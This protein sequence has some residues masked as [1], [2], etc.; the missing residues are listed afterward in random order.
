MI[1]FGALLLIILIVMV[2]NFLM[3]GVIYKASHYSDLR[4]KMITDLINGIKTIK[5][6]CWETIFYQ[7]VKHYRDLQYQ[8]MKNTAYLMSLAVPF[9]F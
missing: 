7:K 3:F 2:L 6:Y 9:L 8:N 1:A 5:A 4:I